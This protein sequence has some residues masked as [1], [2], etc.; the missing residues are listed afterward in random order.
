M[1]KLVGKCF[2]KFFKRAK[3]KL[4]KLCLFFLTSLPPHHWNP[5]LS[6]PELWSARLHRLRT[7]I[8]APAPCSL[9]PLF[10]ITGRVGF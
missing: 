6:R 1:A 10:S 9:Q 7:S 4:P 5:C 3:L 2:L 8:S